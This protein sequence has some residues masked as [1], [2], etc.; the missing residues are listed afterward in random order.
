LCI[1][2]FKSV[3]VIL[4]LLV[5]FFISFFSILNKCPGHNPYYNFTHGYYLVTKYCKKEEKLVLRNFLH[6]KGIFLHYVWGT[7]SQIL[8]NYIFLNN[9]LH[10]H[11]IWIYNFVTTISYSILF[12]RDNLSFK[13]RWINYLF[14]YRLDILF[15]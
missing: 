1:Q 4:S 14:K 8:E 10:L 12:V 9:D 7:P 3:K 6:I 13:I 15:I 11:Q 2:F 5:L